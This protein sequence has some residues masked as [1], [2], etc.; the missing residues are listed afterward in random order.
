M[1]AAGAALIT[2]I[3][4]KDSGVGDIW[5]AASESTDIAGVFQAAQN[6]QLISNGIDYGLIGGVLV[7][8]YFVYSRYNDGRVAIKSKQ[9]E[10]V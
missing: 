9:A 1:L 3:L 8:M 7:W 2:S 10:T 5:T 4:N 6:A